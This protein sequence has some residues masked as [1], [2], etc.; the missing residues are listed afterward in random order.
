MW[1]E[2]II[3]PYFHLTT[4]LGTMYCQMILEANENAR[5]SRNLKATIVDYCCWRPA[6][7]SGEHI[8]VNRLI[9]S[10]INAGQ[11]K[12]LFSFHNQILIT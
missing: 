12:I 2:K 11:I 3:R 5:S 9:Y 1:N 7:V 10:F 6:L 8:N 4:P